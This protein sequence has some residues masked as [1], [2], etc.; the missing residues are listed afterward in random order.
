ML[1]LATMKVA[2][3]LLSPSE[4]GRLSLILATIAFFTLFLVTPVGMFINRRLH[5]WQEHGRARLYLTRYLIYLVVV[6]GIAAIV[7]LVFSALGIMRFGLSVG[8]LIFL[9]CGSLFFNTI[10][11]TVIPSLNLL[12]YNKRF[13]VLTIATNAASFAIAVVVVMATSPQA[14]HWLLGLL[15]GQILMALIGARE[16]SALLASSPARGTYSAVAGA[17]HLRALY[18]FAWPVAIAVGL[19]WVQAQSYRYLLGDLLGLDQLGL[20]VAGYG[21][22]IG[23]VTGFESVLTAY[24][25]PRLYRD[26]NTRSTQQLAQ[27]WRDY[28]AAVIPSLILTIAVIVALAPE[29]V[30][31]FLGERF[32]SAT[33]FVVWGALAEAARVLAS[34]YALIAHVHM[35][36][37]NLVIPNVVGAVLSLAL[38]ALLIPRIGTIGAGIGLSVSGFAIVLMLHL[39][40]IGKLGAGSSLPSLAAPLAGALLLLLCGY[41]MRNLLGQQGWMTLFVT[42]GLTGAVFLTLQLILLRRHLTDR[43]SPGCEA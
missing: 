29:L 31:L 36:T 24:F 8:W 12:G 22:S 13:V 26:A 18:N 23:I 38:C 42:L 32:Y 27:A 11:Q 4:M 37:R 34:V 28:A 43:N 40:L 2:T 20:F 7:L 21:V 5:A 9:V 33:Q 35:N 17:A 15:V 3:M 1:V 10:N 6:A 16:L 25:Q 19:G 41:G 30:H 39:A 14:Q